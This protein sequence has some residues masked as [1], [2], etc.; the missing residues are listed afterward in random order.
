MT[1]DIKL[2][3]DTFLGSSATVALFSF[4]FIL[5]VKGRVTIPKDFDCQH[6]NRH[7]IR[8]KNNGLKSLKN[9]TCYITF[10]NLKERDLGVDTCF[11]YLI[12][13]GNFVKVEKELIIWDNGEVKFD[14][15]PKQSIDIDILHFDKTKNTITIPSE[16][17]YTNKFEY[18]KPR[19][20]ITKLKEYLFYIILCADDYCS[21]EYH[22]KLKPNSMNTDIKLKRYW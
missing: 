17:G 6:K 3:F 12:S 1:F 9:L 2:F 8:V 15:H 21:R 7:R 18:E 20:A 5:I 22:F 10:I 11:K 16:H 13:N 14:L 4:L 19:M